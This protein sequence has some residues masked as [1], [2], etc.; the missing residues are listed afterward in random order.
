M[1][2]MV[3]YVEVLTLSSLLMQPSSLLY[4]Q[5]LG[6]SQISAAYHSVVVRVIIYPHIEL[7]LYDLCI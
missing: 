2:T 1:L 4:S 6:G 7:I 5:R 3:W